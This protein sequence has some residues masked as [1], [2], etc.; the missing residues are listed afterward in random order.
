MCV[1]MDT[2]P[3]YSVCLFG[4]SRVRCGM[5]SGQK[6]TFA[7]SLARPVRIP[8]PSRFKRVRVFCLSSS[9]GTMGTYLDFKK[10]THRKWEMTSEAVAKVALQL[11]SRLSTLAHTTHL[12]Q[13]T[14]K[15]EE[16]KKTRTHNFYGCS[17][18]FPAKHTHTALEDLFTL[19]QKAKANK[20]HDV[21]KRSLRTANRS[22]FP[23]CPK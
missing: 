11:N 14:Q 16:R 6:F 22:W 13:E 9:R 17:C 1:C 15:K 20:T 23:T 5:L 10:K 2:N 19:H 18:S 7:V 4:Q 12:T 3:R 21:N 8:C